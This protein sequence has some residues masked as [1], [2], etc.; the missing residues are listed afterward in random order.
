MRESD[1]FIFIGVLAHFDASPIG[2]KRKSDPQALEARP[3]FL[4]TLAH[5][6]R[7]SDAENM[8]FMI[9]GSRLRTVSEHP[10]QRVWGLRCMVYGLGQYPM[11]K[12]GLKI[13][14]LETV[15]HET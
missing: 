12:V 4:R 15:S 2:V 6:I 14:G 9:Y 7:A 5:S 3:K 13:V 1:P 8:G 10:T 11:Q